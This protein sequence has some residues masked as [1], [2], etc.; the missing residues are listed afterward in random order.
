MDAIDHV[1]PYDRTSAG[2]TC[3][4][5][6]L[7]SWETE[8]VTDDVAQRDPPMPPDADA[9]L[10][11]AI[12]GHR[13]RTAFAALFGKFAPRLK[14]WF[15]QGGCPP[16]QAEDLAQETLLAVWRKAGSFDPNRASAATWIFSIARN[17]RIDA[18]RRTR[19]LLLDADD[20]SLAPPEP[21]NA[22]H[23]FDMAEREM[24]VR[25]AL[26]DLPADQADVI[27]LAYFEDRPHAEIEQNLGIPLGTVKSRLRL[28]MARLRASLGASPEGDFK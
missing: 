25:A 3:A 7:L 4:V 18:F 20:P 5:T 1:R 16:E 12:S 13:D 22:G 28:A 9:A 14:S 8:A 19:T 26:R 24:R 6:A 2:P 15:R 17:L 10:L 21:N 11:L 23:A 27:R